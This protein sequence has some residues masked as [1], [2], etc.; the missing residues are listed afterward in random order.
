MIPN[1]A[2]K[3]VEEDQFRP[4]SNKSILFV[5]NFLSTRGKGHGVCEELAKRLVA[6]SG[7]AVLT[8]SNRLN[9]FFRLA[10]MVWTVWK[11]RRR[12]DVA[13]VDVYSGR[14]FAWAEIAALLLKCLG[15]PVVLTLRGG[16]LPLFA[17]NNSLRVRRLLRSCAI[18]TAPSAYLVERMRGLGREILLLPNPVEVGRYAYRLRSQVKPRLVWL[19]AFHKVYNPMLAPRILSALL[20]DFPHSHLVMVGPDKGDGSLHET[21]KVIQDLGL[22]KRISIAGSALKSAVPK[23]LQEGDIFIN[24]TNIDNTPVSVLE[25]MACGLC[26]VSTD[27]GGIPYLLEHE[28]DAL[29]V[30]PDDPEAMAAAVRRLLTEP[31]LARKLSYNARKKAEQFDWSRILPQWEA[32]LQSV[33]GSAEKDVS[34]ETTT[35]PS[36]KTLNGQS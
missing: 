3:P 22:G 33:I 17:L 4:S 10:D 14:A 15:K 8:T 34:A 32:L 9:G 11:Y 21:K 26:V 35:L 24:T 1:S 27:V 2:Q 7:Y 19:R 5:G 12:Y 16:N 20:Q 28:H 18:A 31:D 13:H 36:S 25:A 23:W 30:P 6:E 29:L